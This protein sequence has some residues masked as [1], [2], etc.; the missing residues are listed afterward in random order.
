MVPDV[1]A[2]G[3]QVTVNEAP[4]W[5]LDRKFEQFIIIDVADCCVIMEGSPKP[6]SA[7]DG[8]L[9]DFPQSFEGSILI[10]CDVLLGQ[11]GEEADRIL[12]SIRLFIPSCALVSGY[13]FW[14][15]GSCVALAFLLFFH[16]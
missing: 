15:F 4:E 3:E 10:V 16:C 12:C 2:L 6:S 5:A 8:R 1:V 7:A 9:L 11:G 13:A 14:G